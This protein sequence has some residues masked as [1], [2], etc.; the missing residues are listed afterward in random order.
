M[1]ENKREKAIEAISKDPNRIIK[2]NPIINA[3]FDITTVQMKVF[4]KIIASID[5]SKDDISE[6]QISV[7]ELQKF[8]GRTSKNI[9]KYLQDELVKLKQRNIFY[10]DENIRLDTN[11]LSS[12]IYYKKLGYFSF[13]IPKALKPF[14]LQI[15]ENFTV[16]DIRNMLFLESIY[17][18]RLYEYCKEFERFKHFEIDVDEIKERFGIADRYKNYFDFKLKVINQA[19]TELMKNSELYFDF[20][21]I[22]EG[23]KI[24][25]LRFTVIKNNKQVSNDNVD[26]AKETDEKELEI[27]ELVRMFVADSTVKSW[28]EKYPYEQIKRAVGYTLNHTKTGTIKDVGAYLQKMVATADLFDPLE[29]IKQEQK[30]KREKEKEIKTAKEQELVVE[31]AKNQIKAEFYNAK[32]DLSISLLTEEIGLFYI[33]LTQ[34]RQENEQEHKPFLAEMA[35]NNYKVNSRFEKNSLDEFIFNLEEGGSFA[36][37][38]FDYLQEV[39]EGTYQKLKQDFLPKA[40]RVGV[41]ANELV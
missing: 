38:V 6:V 14:L 20:D 5:Q 13:E 10:E 11:L 23:K 18:M 3:R 1:E 36:S 19:R 9:H 29:L 21:E 33:I 30:K 12:I 32:K 26:V 31:N 37:Y 17:A 15:K 2:T 25:R 27:I 8:V 4:L 40:N 7:A 22:K 34:L 41:K 35:L 28:F 39:Y 16:L 24:V